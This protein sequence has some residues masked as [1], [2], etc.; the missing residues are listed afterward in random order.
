MIKMP[1]LIVLGILAVWAI[2]DIAVDCQKK[3]PGVKDW[4]AYNRDAVGMDA[5]EIRKGLKEGRW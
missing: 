1:L 5:K 2:Y 3:A 4:D